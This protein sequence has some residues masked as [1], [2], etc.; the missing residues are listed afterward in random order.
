MLRADQQRNAGQFSVCRPRL[1]CLE[2]RLLMSAS[3]IA[4]VAEVATVVVEDSAG[5]DTSTDFPAELTSDLPNEDSSNNGA[6]Y[7]T[8]VVSNLS[9]DQAPGVD[10]EIG[11]SEADV[12]AAAAIHGVELI[13]IDS[14][15]ADA[16]GLLDGLL[17]EDRDF[18]LLRLDGTEDGIR[19][20]TDRLQQ[21]GNVSAIHL[22]SHGGVGEIH[23]GSSLL[24]SQT[25]SSH[26]A[27]LMAWRSALTDGAD[28]LIYGCNVAADSA[29]LLLLDQMSALTGA[30]VAASVDDTGNAVYGGDWDLEYQ[31]GSIQTN[32]ALSAEIQQGWQG[33]LAVITV[34]TATDVVDAG[35]GLTSLREAINQANAGSGGDTIAFNISGAG[36]HT[37]NVASA[38]PFITKAVTIDGTTQSGFAGRPLIVIDGNGGNQDGLVLTSTADGSTIRGLAI[39]DFEFNAI[40]INIGSEGHFIEGNWLGALDPVTGEFLAGEQN[41]NSGVNVEGSNVTVGGTTAAQQNVISGNL[42]SGIQIDGVTATGNVIIGNLIGTNSSATSVVASTFEGI[43]LLNGANNNIIGGTA[44]GSANVISGNTLGGVGIYN[45]SRD[46][47]IQGNFIGT[48]TTGSAN[49]GTAGYGI[50][51]FDTAANNIIGG[52]GTN[53]GNVIANSGTFGVGL[54]GTGTGNSIRGNQIYNSVGLGIDLEVDGV[55]ANDGLDADT[56]ANG[57]QNFPVLTTAAMSGS[58]ITITGTFD[59]NNSS[60]FDIDFYVSAIANGSGHGEAGRYLGSTSVTTTAGGS[61][62]INA[63]LTNVL[64][65]AGE[66]ITAT[67]TDASGN[68]SEFAANITA[69][70]ATTMATTGEFRVNTTTADSQV[71]SAATLG[72]GQAVSVAA[73]GSYTVVWSSLNQ[74]G[75][76]WGVYARRFNAVGVAL[77]GEIQVAQ[78]TANDQRWA[79]VGSAADGSFVVT[80]RQDSG[81]APQEV[82]ARRFAADG[83]ALGNEFIVNTTTAGQ[84]SNSSIAVNGS[85]QFVVVWEG[86]GT[87]DS[88]GVFYRRFNADGTAMDA[89]ERRAHDATG[90]TTETQ[91]AVDMNDSGQFVIVWG[92]GADVFIRHFDNNGDPTHSAANG[93]VAISTEFRPAVAISEDGKSVLTART[94]GALGLGSGVWFSVWDTTGTTLVSLTQVSSPG[95]GSDNTSP[96]LLMDDVGNFAIVYHGVDN[97]DG[98]G[99]SVKLVRYTVEGVAQG[100]A[101]QVNVSTAGNQHSASVALLDINNFVVVWSGAGDQTGNVD[102][103]GV[104]ARQYHLAPPVLDLD[105]DDSSGATGVDFN[106]SFTSG[107]GAVAVVDADATLS[108]ADNANL[109]S[110]TVR[111]TDRQNGSSEVLAANTSGTSISASYSFGTLTLSGVDTVANYQKVLR[112]VTYDNGMNPVTGTSRTITFIASDGLASNPVAA[113]HLTI[114]GPVNSAP[115]AA[116]GGSYTINE[117][118]VLHLNAGGSNDPDGDTMTFEWDLDNDGNYGEAGEPTAVT[119]SVNWANLQSFGFTNEGT[120]SIGVR[121]SDGQGGID[122]ATASV[123]VLNLAPTFTSSANVSVSENTTAVQTVTATDP[124]DTVTYAITGGADAAKFTINSSTGALSFLAAPDFESPGDVGGNNV[125]DVMVEADDGVDSVSQAISVAVANANDAP[126]NSVPATQTTDQNTHLVFN[127]ANS[128]LITISDSDA[129]T[130]AVEVTLTA[131]NGTVS[132]GWPSATATAAGGEILL[133]TTTG[134]KQV[135]LDGGFFGATTNDFGSPRAIA[136]GPSGNFVVT[137]SSKDQDSDK[138]GVYAQQFNADGIK[139][140]AEFRV[141]TT[142]TDDQ[143]HASVAMDDDGNFVITWSSHNQDGDKWGVYAQLFNAAGVKQGAEFRVNT[144]TGSEQLGSTVAMDADGNFVIAWSSKDQDSDKY[145]IYA[146]RFDAAGGALGGEFRVNNSTADDQ[147]AASIAMAADRSFVVTWS[148]HNQDGDT[149]GVYAKR[150]DA[151]GVSQG[152]EFLVNTETSREQQFSSVATDDQGNF[153][154]TWSSK[155]QDGDKWGVYAQRYTASGVAQGS[156]FLVNTSTAKE[157]RF[158]SVSMDSD[159]DFAITWT[160]TDQDGDKLGIYV[161]Q[162]SAAGV[163]KGGEM[164][165]NSTTTGDQSYSSIAMDAKGSF[166]VVWM[167]EGTGDAEGIFARRYSVPTNITL[168]A[169]DGTKDTSITFT[170]TIAQINTALDGLSFTPAAGFNGLATLTINTDDLG[171][172]GPGGARTDSDII[173]ISVGTGNAAP[174]LTLPSS[175]ATFTENGAAVVIDA[176]ATASDVDS[177]DLDGG[178][179]T[180]FLN[181]NGASADRLGIRSQGTA[182]GQIGISGSDITYN[183]GSGA[184]IIG[185]FDGGTDGVTPL[186]VNLNSSATTAAVQKLMRNITFEN[187]SEDPGSLS[188]TVV[189]RLTDGDGGTSALVQQT[190][191]VTAVNDAPV[192]DAAQSFSVS[193]AAVNGTS[194]GTVLATDAEAGTTL[195]NW[196][197]ASGNSDSI[198]SINN[199]TGELTVVDNANLDFETN[200]SY[201]LGIIVSDGVTPSLVQTISIVVVD[202][203]DTGP[204]AV[205]DSYSLAEGGTLNQTVTS[206]WFNSNWEFRQQ[207][208]FDNST[209]A[210]NLLDMPIL[211]KLHAS[212]ADAIS[213][214]YSATQDAGEDLRFVD[215]DGTVLDYQIELWDETG[216]SYVWVRVPQIDAGSTTDSISMY[217]GNA[218]AADG[219]NASAVWTSQN[220]AVFHLNL[221]GLDAT[222]NENH[223]GVSNVI[224]ANG[225]IAGAGSFNGT[226]SYMNAQSDGTVDNI[227]DSGGTISAWINPTGWGEGGYGRIVDKGA[228]TTGAHGWGFQVAGTTAANGYLI[229]EHDFNLTAGRWRTTAGSVSL[230]TWQNVVVTYDKGSSL[231]APRIFIDGVEQSLAQMSVPAGLARSDSAQSLFIGNRSGYID[232]TFQG[233]IDEVRILT[234]ALTT[235]EIVAQYRTGNGNFV[236]G[237]TVQTGPGGLL[238]NDSH[239][240]SRTMAVSLVSGPTHAAS[241]TLNADGSFN[242]VHDGSECATDSFVYQVNDGLFTDTAT[243]ILTITPVN[244]STPV[245]TSGQSFSVSESAV[246]G[247]SLGTVTAA[248]ADAGTTL[249]GWSITSGNVDGIFGINATTGALTVIDRTKLDFETTASYSLGISVSDGLHTSSPQNVLINVTNT[250]DTAP[251]ITPGQSLTM[252]ESA[253]N[254]TTPG[255]IGATDADGATVFSN[256]TIISGN[257]AGVFSINAATGQIVVANNTSVDFDTAPSYTLTLTVSDGLNTSSTETVTINVSN[258]NVATPVV[259]PGQTFVV[260]EAA[261][262]GTN[263]G[264]VVATDD[265]G[266]TIFSNWTISSGN[267]DGIFAIN[268][269]TGAVTVIDRTKLDFE[270]VTSYS[271][272]ITVSDGLHISSAQDV[273]ITVTNANDEKPVITPGQSFSVS[274]SAVTGILAGTLVATDSDGGTTFSNWTI[275]SGNTDGVFS[276]DATSGQL[277]IVDNTNLDFESTPGYSLGITVSDGVNISNVQVV[278]IIVTDTN[279]SSPVIIP[280]QIFTVSEMAGNGTGFGTVLATDADAGDTAAFAIVGGNISGAFAVNAASGQLQVADSSVL[281]F[282]STSAYSL[283]IQVTDSAGHQSSSTIAVS[284]TDANDAPVIT[285]PVG[286]DSVGLTVVENT[287]AVTTV[288]ATD[289]DLPAQTLRYSIAGGDDAS[290]FFIYSSS[291]FLRFISP[292]DFESPT[293]VGAD[294]VYEVVVQV[295]DGSRVDTQSLAITVT[296]ANDAPGITNFGSAASATIDVTEGTTIVTTVT[297]SDADG[298]SLAYSIENG[299][300]QSRFA[301]DAAT[302]LLTFVSAPDFEA[303]ADTNANNVYVVT[304]KAEDGSGASDTQLLYVR[305]AN[306]NEQPTS[307]TITSILVAEDSAPGVMSAAAAF[308]DPDGDALTYSLR[309][310]SDTDTVL[311]SVTVDSSTG[312]VAWRLNPNAHGTAQLELTATDSGGLSTSEQ[313]AIQVTPVNDA[314]VVSDKAFFVSAGQALA[315]YQSPELFAATDVDG[316]AVN[317][318]LVQP[319]Q[320]GTL[321]VNNNGTVTY[322]AN[323]GFAGTD[324]FQFQV[325]DGVL[326][327]GV[328]TATIT[329]RTL[330]VPMSNSPTEAVPSG[331]SRSASSSGT[332]SG[333]SVP[334]IVK[335]PGQQDKLL[336]LPDATG[337][338]QSPGPT[339]IGSDDDD[340]DG[341]A[342]SMARILDDA[343]DLH[344]A[345]ISSLF[346]VSA[347]MDQ[348]VTSAT[349]R[350]L[351]NSTTSR[352]ERERSASDS[353]SNVRLETFQLSQFEMFGSTGRPVSVSDF[354]E[355]DLRDQQSTRNA[356]A[357]SVQVV[358]SGLSVGYVI[359]MLRGGMLLTG[360]LAQMPAWRMLDPLMVIDG[361]EAVDDGE[362]IQSI[363]NDQ[364]AK[365][366]IADAINK[367]NGPESVVDR[368][369]T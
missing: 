230:N 21:L 123:T 292:V 116:S 203:A 28:V 366:G 312:Q 302:G 266:G 213:I 36:V 4:V 180:V 146:R 142:T 19:Q 185:S 318:Q 8:S 289:A 177:A 359:W 354:L 67:A 335:E 78:T 267:A 193:E 150:F 328:A 26:A 188:R 79:Q 351:D 162:Y 356:V 314:P 257:T 156:E 153:V 208:T 313:F 317:L 124:N 130:S 226:D 66:F 224:V 297:S 3:P 342:L 24:N 287:Y 40:Q 33:K 209:S 183:F 5:A 216:Y 301:I 173:N 15:V 296:N 39:R 327:S 112:T 119:A 149:W 95:L 70:G 319:T 136:S 298:D 200:S 1:S 244:D 358:A 32:V 52:I 195:G 293:D 252:P 43:R 323:S 234:S 121:V 184:V 259:T 204:N 268:S 176:A 157:Q 321:V 236:I 7:S 282:E 98:N 139:Q 196:Q 235:D 343:D 346:A 286:V 148:S 242:Y 53:E 135:T 274:E 129:G 68:T 111:I 12:A 271:M 85:G 61:A 362:S 65:A 322:T 254:G 144:E 86:E 217:Y 45:A 250:N 44:A 194:L 82:Y 256:W 207:L 265:D 107:G 307:A 38:L 122:T 73:D 151:E 329:V 261:A 128:N 60:T 138:W 262:N 245:V 305:V 99:Q 215:T 166:V 93:G 349:L 290:K 205:N 69:T 110:L 9:E 233:S 243:V 158:S 72:S 324:T 263:L 90:S 154:V 16:D 350:G 20:I 283:T 187:V 63:T 212:A 104:F 91:S 94:N 152:S 258:Q 133:N 210:T 137:W 355:Q 64:V 10:A 303:P 175:A 229:F 109:Q 269:A 117:G 277:T 363:I 344:G 316:Q 92:D 251:V 37:I 260:S 348:L 178:T 100:A 106:A 368:M 334:Q 331:N 58:S 198:F 161:R 345:Q 115:S 333:E 165:V 87:G 56:G 339:D 54:G 103:S 241:F 285:S 125:Y 223:G 306:R 22:I 141:N 74:D 118:G 159:G 77:T 55:T 253:A 172:T 101:A 246:N 191:N 237:S 108:D 23:L 228:S 320:F 190:V 11:D 294:N 284:I 295:S 192:V 199:S 218:L 143:A 281:D 163:A 126:V 330:A 174:I 170:G 332:D 62:A 181:A 299:A 352:N 202:A 357:G 255:T 222:V 341:S 51:T 182:S 155:D 6:L 221:T 59:G 75:S 132:L 120:Y 325:S 336:T 140:G 114:A 353:N 80:W 225:R 42:F 160:S 131:T 367:Q 13:V 227:F 171:N 201:T 206:D 347:N 364:E 34:T 288:T 272:G 17:A 326:S 41:G 308:S 31:T 315:I 168:T 309:V 76:G 365:L 89:T 2:E 310:L 231:N 189:F 337:S 179:L 311:R 273:V 360:L 219:Q 279:D 71:T 27:E 169:G 280:G 14:N 270:S 214:D 50:R 57:L 248:D 240:E 35:D 18:R 338:Q 145:G 197:I 147:T 369:D 300:D 46:N 30:D 211:V 49:L 275:T 83:T 304:V 84:Q 47:T 249:S 186:E 48:D 340:D 102:T 167:G 81:G 291:G 96:S 97:G 264:S 105:A 361:E 88:A 247:A 127:A 232:R 276:I 25:L 220:A 239:P 113:T 278:S 134:N 29:G 164:L 238:D